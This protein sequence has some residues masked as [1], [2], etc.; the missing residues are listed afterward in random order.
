MMNNTAYSDNTVITKALAE[1][2]KRIPRTWRVEVQA[3]GIWR[4][5]VRPDA[6]V[7]LT[8]PG[9][10]RAT[11]LVEAKRSL[12][13]K[14]IERAV[15]QLRSMA[16]E[17][18]GALLVVAPFLGPR[19]REKLAAAGAGYVDL[20]G[21][22]LLS[23]EEP[24]IYIE[25][26]GADI[27]PDPIERPARSL[28][29]AKTARIIRTLIDFRG[30]LGTRQIANMTDTDPGYVSRVLD[31][32]DRGAFI[33]R[34]PRGPVEEVKWRELLVRWTEDYSVLDSNRVISYLEPR[35]VDALVARLKTQDSDSQGAYAVTGS[36]A[37]PRAAAVAPA[38]MAMLYVQNAA[39]WA[40]Q[41]GLTPTDTGSNVLLIE[42]KDP[43]VFARSRAEEGLRRVAASQCAADLLTGPGRNPAEGEALLAWMEQNE[44]EWR[45]AS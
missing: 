35:G 38:R 6:A 5:G 27:N 11:L 32:L 22:V 23:L 16:D 31:L 17:T 39:W 21:N 29:G 1:L 41:L 7:T 20:T 44:G 30:P 45:Y 24:A 13:P 26:Q 10:E 43:V 25:R 37:V 14:D 15:D 2:T 33:V 18:V 36:L 40:S 8:A 9:G 4:A 12:E 3:E 42:P 28:K 19:V 34:K